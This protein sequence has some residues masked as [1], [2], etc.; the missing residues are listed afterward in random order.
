MLVLFNVKKQEP[1]WIQKITKWFPA[2]ND[3]SYG[4]VES[5][6]ILATGTTSRR[7]VC[8]AAFQLISHPRSKTAPQHQGGGQTRA[9]TR[10]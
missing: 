7:V 3:P 6:G 5:P 9:Y 8:G 10:G 4:M 2:S 1:K